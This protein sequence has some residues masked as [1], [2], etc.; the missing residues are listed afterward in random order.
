MYRNRLW[1]LESLIELLKPVGFLKIEQIIIYIS[2]FLKALDSIICLEE[3]IPLFS[4]IL[5][6]R[7]FSGVL[8]TILFHSNSNEVE[9]SK[10]I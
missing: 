6:L 8:Y 2:D 7:Y 5:R 10:A 3:S 9:L 1:S 4:I